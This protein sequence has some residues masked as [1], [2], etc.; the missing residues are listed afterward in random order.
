MPRV[1]KKKNFNVVTH[2]VTNVFISQLDF[3]Q[4][5]FRIQTE[6]YKR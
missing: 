4:H 1:L 3:S 6:A 2:P 5:G